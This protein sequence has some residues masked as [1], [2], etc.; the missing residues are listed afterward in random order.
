MPSNLNPIHIYY[1]SLLDYGCGIRLL[2]NVLNPL[3]SLWLPLILPRLGF[4]PLALQ[5]LVHVA[6]RKCSLS[7]RMAAGSVD[8]WRD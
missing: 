6:P 7:V 8:E 1:I 4:P 2:G 5:D 3:G